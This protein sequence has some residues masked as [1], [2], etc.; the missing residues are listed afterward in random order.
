MLII[1]NNKV[2]LAD[3]ELSKDSIGNPINKINHPSFEGFSKHENDLQ[4]GVMRK[5]SVQGENYY[6]LIVSFPKNT[7]L[8]WKILMIAQETDFTSELAAT[9]K[10]AIYIVVFLLIVMMLM[11]YFQMSFIAEP[12]TSVSIEA[13]KIA[14]LDLYDDFVLKSSVQEIGDMSNAI[15]NMK[16]TITN[17]SKFIPKSLVQR[18]N[19]SHKKIRIGGESSYITL[20]F[21]DIQG[22]STISEKMKPED[23]ALHLSEYF[24]ELTQIILENHGTVDKFIG[25]A[26]MTFWGAPDADENQIVNACYSALL[27]KQ[28]LDALNKYWESIGKPILITRFGIHSGTCVVGNVGSDERMSYTALGDNV[29][30]SAR[31]EGAS[32]NY[33][34]KILISKEVEKLLPSSFIRRSIDNIAVK[35]K[36]NSI[37]VFELIGVIGHPVLYPVSA[38]KIEYIAKFD[39]M[40]ELY[41]KK[42]WEKTINI[43]EGLR[44]TKIGEQDQTML[45]LY[46]QLCTELIANPPS[47]EWDSVRHLKE[48]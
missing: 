38:E 32:K 28:R 40:V 5:L 48:K 23:L 30:L 15:Q 7:G 31:L 2:I 4:S 46:T 11:L 19:H 26:I 35:G 43:I 39:A 18:L 22:F 34:T 42:E 16:H 3:S 8:N 10:S 27:C 20:M 25:D 44:K 36:S 37:E 29:N 17:L 41:R 33:G 1:D 13:R 47:Q 12:I 45:D 9:E 24:Q 21:S 6:Y 14:Q